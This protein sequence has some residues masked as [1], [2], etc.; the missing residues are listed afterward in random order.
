M[1][2]NNIKTKKRILDLH[3]GKISNRE[4]DQTV[5]KKQVEKK[6]LRDLDTGLEL[7]F[8]IAVPL[9]GG[10][11]LGSYLDKMLGT[12]PKVTLSLIF[13]GLIISGFYLYKIIKDNVRN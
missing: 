9:V 6:L 10:A 12:T 5:S 7:G 8:G 4:E 11:L 3:L 13:L 2:M 1:R